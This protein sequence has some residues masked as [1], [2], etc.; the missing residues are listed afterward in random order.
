MVDFS[1]LRKQRQTAEPVDPFAIF[2]RLP[3]PPHMNDLWDGQSKALEAWVKRRAE[4]DLVIKLNTGGGKTLVGLLIGQSLLNEL[5]A[6]VLYLCPTKQLVEQTLEKAGE[7]T[8]P[9]VS[10]RG[11]FDEFLNANAICIATYKALFNGLSKFG[12]LGSGKEPVK[13]GGVI[14]DDAH[15]AFGTVRESFT[16]SIKKAE[17]PEIYAEIAGRFRSDINAVGRGGTFDDVVERGDAGI[18]EVPYPAWFA[19]SG[20]V[21]QL[22]AREH[23]EEFK[24][25]LPLLRDFFPLSHAFINARE[26]AITAMQPLVHLFPSFAECKRRVFMSATIADDS[27]I[28]RTFDANPKAIA[29]PI[30][31]ESLAG[32][33]ERMI[34]APSLMNIKEDAIDVAKSVVEELSKKVGTVVLVQ[35]EWQAKQDW[36]DATTIATEDDVAT[37]VRQLVTGQSTG[38]FTFPNRYDGLDLVA[39][40]C[41]LLVLHGLP[42]ATNAYEL[43]RAEVLRGNSSINIG[44]AQRFEQGIGRGTRGAGDY[45]VVLLVGKDLTSWISRSES[46]ALLT[47]ST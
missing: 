43:F 33:G 15:S 19:K 14:C 1:E 22:I 35:S 26:I 23:A 39:N 41:R 38:P 5:K 12:V 3:K 32:V 17:M 13:L 24:F 8:I 27:A 40:A 7:V 29:T 16:I 34:L 2:K 10:Y 30:I 9:A 44:I 31:P 4:N 6:P 25:V 28:V 46:L 20:E 45:C 36:G 21:R 37:A 18:I 42:R 47:P 11:D